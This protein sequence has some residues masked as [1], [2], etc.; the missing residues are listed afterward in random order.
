MA[1]S[2]KLIYMEEMSKLEHSTQV[3]EV[4]P[5]ENEGDDR[6]VVILAETVFYPQGG[7]QPWDT[8]TIEG[9]DTKFNV[10]EVR[11]VDGVVHHIGTGDVK[12]G[13]EV[14]C[15]VEPKRRLL[16][17][18]CHSGGHMIDLALYEMGVTW[19]PAKGYHFPNGPYDEFIGTLPE[20]REKFKADLETKCNEI[21]E[22]GAETEVRF[23]EKEQMKDI[24]LHVPDYLPEGK[25]GRLVMYGDWGMPCGG[26]H[27]ANLKDI[28]KMT[29]RKVKQEKDRVRIAYDVSRD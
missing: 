5:G 19:P 13:D 8:G 9:A 27:V 22:R 24:C 14:T 28:G 17:T 1:D 15:H 16:N 2:T 7:G 21:I 3:V 11:F 25:P 23:M 10:E 6:T 4:F 26:T 18:R 20:D 29:I 12:P